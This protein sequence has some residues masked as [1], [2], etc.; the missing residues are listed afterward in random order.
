MRRTIIWQR[1]EENPFQES[2]DVR[3]WAGTGKRLVELSLEAFSSVIHKVD[4]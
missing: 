1:G 2:A 3:L 4:G